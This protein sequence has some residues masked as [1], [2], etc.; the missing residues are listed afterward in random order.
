MKQNRSC[1]VSARRPTRLLFLTSDLGMGGAE[2]HAIN[3]ATGLDPTKVEVRLLCVEQRG[4]RFGEIEAAGVLAGSLDAGDRWWLSAP[5]L[6][7]RLRAILRDFGI[8]IVMTNGYSAEV[9]GRLAAC[10]TGVPV[11]AW[12][13]N[14]GHIGRFGTRDRLTERVLGHWNRRYLA[15]SHRQ[16]DYLVDQMGVNR[17]AITVIHNSV[18]PVN[19]MSLDDRADLRR[20]LGIAPE[21]NVIICVAGLRIE[22]DHATLLHAFARVRETRR[23]TELCLIGDGPEHARL[24]RLAT[25]LGVAQSVRFT[26]NRDDVERLMQIGHVAVLASYAIENFPY[27]ILEAMAAG[28]PAVCTN[29]GGIPEMIDDGITG[30][31]VPP[32]DPEALATAIL[33][34]LSPIRQSKMGTAARERLINTFPYE[35]FLRQVEEVIKYEAEH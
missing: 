28:V 6:T 8:D 5:G 12:K 7:L 15:V 25:D 30:R 22:K 26:G 9:L 23:D 16:V 3:I 21:V 31:L 32:H 13:H 27:A 29:V 19:S 24:S 17:G 1:K 14:F 2:R 11:V 34:V 18:E 33:W 4:E 10:G 20:D 35:R